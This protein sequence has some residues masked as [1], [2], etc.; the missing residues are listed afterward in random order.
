MGVYR[1]GGLVDTLM[2]IR[3]CYLLLGVVLG[4]LLTAGLVLWRER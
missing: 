1:I 4:F 3:V 2:I